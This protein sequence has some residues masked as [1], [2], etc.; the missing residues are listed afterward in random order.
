MKTLTTFIVIACSVQLAFAET[1]A[2]KAEFW[3]QKGLAAEKSGD[4]STAL[5]AY[6][7]ALEL[8][9]NHANA[10]YRA[11]EVKINANNLK[12]DAKEAKLGAIMIP[13][14]QIEDLTVQEALSVLTVAIEKQSKEEITPN[15]II[16]DPNKKLTDVKV[17]LNIKNVPVSAILKYIHAQSNTNIRYDE[18]A[19]VIVAR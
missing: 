3:Y 11:G 2:E 12:A 19:V 8:N 17:T 5:A 18:H 4:P 16:E 14:Y 9:A 6:K 13:A 10:R 15:F 1:A 7:A